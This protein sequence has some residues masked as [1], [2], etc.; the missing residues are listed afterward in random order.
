[1]LPRFC[2]YKLKQLR[3]TACCGQENVTF[4][5]HIHRAWDPTFRPS[6]YFYKQDHHMLRGC[7]IKR[8][9]EDTKGGWLVA[10][11]PVTRPDLTC[12]KRRW[13]LWDNKLWRL[14]SYAAAHCLLPSP[15]PLYF[16][17]GKNQMILTWI[18]W[19]PQ[20][21]LHP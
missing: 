7:H 16:A 1:M 11:S 5:P 9:L 15:H 13:Y 6:L 2:E 20:C 10:A 8:P 19:I 18:I 12:E 4:P 14:T 3:F 17:H 21:F